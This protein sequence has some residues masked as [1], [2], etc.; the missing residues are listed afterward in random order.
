MYGRYSMKS[1][2]PGD[3]L[4]RSY[5][6]GGFFGC[7]CARARRLFCGCQAGAIGKGESSWLGRIFFCGINA[8]WKP[9]QTRN[10]RSPWCNHRGE[11]WSKVKICPRSSSFL[12]RASS[13][14]CR[15]ISEWVTHKW[16]AVQLAA[17]VL[18]PCSP[19][20]WHLSYFSRQS[21]PCCWCSNGIAPR[22]AEPWAAGKG[23]SCEVKHPTPLKPNQTTRIRVL[24]VLVL[25]CGLQKCPKCLHKVS[26]EAPVL[27]VLPRELNRGRGAPTLKDTTYISLLEQIPAS[28]SVGFD[29]G[30]FCCVFT[31][32]V[33]Q[34]NKDVGHRI[35]R[36][37]S[38]F[39]LRQ[40]PV[41]TASNEAQ[42]LI[43]SVPSLGWVGKKYEKEPFL[44]VVVF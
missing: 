39:W 4:R 27:L 24:V 1:R 17:C 26:L 9:N 19:Q 8:L 10:S 21:A 43:S 5:P 29:P 36:L 41:A 11:F 7:V 15:A 23:F 31:Y 22:P 38:L 34:Q 32:S 35:C 44:N 37:K 3:T 33:M 30:L 2:S 16:H 25:L 14:G 20:L 12:G 40:M 42:L 18:C 28:C 6:L 13:K